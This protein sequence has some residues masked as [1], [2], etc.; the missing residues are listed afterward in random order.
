MGSGAV[1]EQV[2]VLFLIMIVG[3]VAA[4]QD[5][6][7]GEV[8]K[9]LSDLLLYITA[10]FLVITA[11][12][13]KFSPDILKNAGIILAFSFVAHVGSILLGMVLFSKYPINK[14]RVLKHMIVFSNCG[15]MGFPV[16]ESMFG[17]I[18]VFYGSIYNLTFQVFVW[19]Y[20]VILFTGNRKQ[21]ST[22]KVLLNPGVASVII[23]MLIFIFSLEIPKPIF[24][25]LE[26]VGGMTAPLSMLIVGA[27]L[28]SIKFKSIFSGF[29]VYYGSLIRLIV[30]PL[31]S[32]G[33][34]KLIGVEELLLQV[35]VLLVAMPAA[36]NTALFAEKYDAD[37]ILASR[38]VALSTILSI[39][40]IPL[41]MMLT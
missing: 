10:P 15:Y 33:V 37:P 17:K 20:G 36:A 8:R 9:K 14:Q 34:L 25:A 2:M 40:T 38:G 31:I 24:Q 22:G 3:M 18:G 11:F 1:V 6:I 21:T 4:K 23:G 27:L 28:S 12:N 41:I 13:F 5:I 29:E 16:L 30:I 32:F 7:N 26:M 35:S 39:I 19:T